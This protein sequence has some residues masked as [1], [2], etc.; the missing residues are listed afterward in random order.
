MTDINTILI[1]DILSKQEN[2]MQAIANNASLNTISSSTALQTIMLF[3]HQIS[4][5]QWTFHI[6]KDSII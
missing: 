3:G 6:F 2:N 5:T 1:I 4:I